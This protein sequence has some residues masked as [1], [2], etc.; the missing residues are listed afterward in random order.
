MQRT[1]NVPSPSPLSLSHR[2][3]TR[4]P[5]QVSFAAWLKKGEFPLAKHVDFLKQCIIPNIDRITEQD[6]KFI[7]LSFLSTATYFYASSSCHADA[8]HKR[9][10]PQF[11]DLRNRWRLLQNV[12]TPNVQQ[13]S[14]THFIGLR[15]ETSQGVT[16]CVVYY[17]M[18]CV[19]FSYKLI[20]QYIFR[21]LLTNGFD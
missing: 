12:T 3:R 6:G 5:P 13:Q 20:V 16:S 18:K 1:E 14:T 2:C 10:T 11:D 15:V 17:I 21:Y 4:P 19:Q 8:T 7:N 9:N